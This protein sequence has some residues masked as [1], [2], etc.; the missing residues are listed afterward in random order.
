[1]GRAPHQGF[2]SGD[3][4]RDRSLVL[5]ALAAVGLDGYGQH[6]FHTLSGGEK[7]RCLLARALAQQPQLMVLDEPTNH[8]DPRHQIELLGLVRRLGVATLASIHDLN[9][10]AAF[11]D[12]LYVIH[13]GRLVADGSP[14][15]VLTPTL[16]HEVFGAHALVDK[17]PLHDYPRI[18]WIT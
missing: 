17:H 18:T 15:D 12:R 5:E 1:M 6:R 9:L 2:F 10:A 14:W 11:C 16:L 4:A 8:L 7:Q 13:H 3:S